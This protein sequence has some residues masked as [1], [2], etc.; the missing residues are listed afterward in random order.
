MGAALSWEK[1][2]L[3]LRPK[4][5]KTMTAV[6]KAWLDLSAIDVPDVILLNALRDHGA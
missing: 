5:A 1:A 4:S 3:S 2:A 6:G